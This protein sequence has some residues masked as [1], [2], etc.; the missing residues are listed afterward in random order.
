MTSFA[1]ILIAN[2][3]EIAARIARTCRQ[4]GIATVAVYS[5]ADAHAPFVADCDEAVRLPGA[6]AA[7]TYL[8]VDLVV[9]AALATGADA[10]HPG[11]GFLSESPHLAA[12][13]DEAGVTFI[14]PP[15]AAIA[16]MSSKIEAKATMRDAGVPVLEGLDASG[17]DGAAL[18]AAAGTLGYPLLAKGS[19]SGGGKGI[20][21]V[22]APDGLADAVAVA[23]REALA[24][25]GDGTVL[26]ERYLEGAR[27]VE[28]Q[29]IADDHGN[30]AHLFERE[31]SIQRRHQKIIEEC[32]SPVVDAALRERMGQAA[33]AATNAVG[34][35]GAGTVEFLLAG[36]GFYFME[37]NTRL[38]VEHP[39]TEMVTGLDLVRLQIRV[40]EGEPLPPE[41]TAATITGH[42]IEAR[43]YAEDPAAGFLPAVGR[44]HRFRIPVGVR[45][46]AGVADGS[47]VTV[48]YDPLLAKVIAHAPTRHE[49][50]AA[51]AR[52][53]AGAELYGVTTNR[54]LLVGILRS[55]E[56]LTGAT[57][58]GFIDRID[59]SA[60]A[61]SPIADVAGHA[62]AATLGH[63][64]RRRATAAVQASIPSGWRN[65]PSQ[66]QVQEWDTESGTTVVGYR[67]DREGL[68]AEIDGSPLAATLHRADA[69]DV[70]L[71]IGGVRRRYRMLSV[72]DTTWVSSPL[73]QATLTRLRRFPDPVVHEAPG[74]LHSPMP[75]KVVAVAVEIG[76]EVAAGDTIVVIEAM[77]MEHSVRS[78]ATGVVA[79][80]TVTVGQQV[81]AH[82]V[83][84]V[85]EA[86]A[87][88]G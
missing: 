19:A 46:D 37:M 50:A 33:V 16:A 17:L 59:V 52:A 28:I 2:R 81:D 35:V 14:G 68:V 32:P 25:F 54:D 36:D 58:T 76:A 65:A 77:K 42:A 39:V 48:H 49:A 82:Q 66:L 51:L 7:D 47:E 85:V 67:F 38:Q 27:H 88:A 60:M 55:H 15:A 63:Q 71:T 75:G 64:A 53:L 79:A 41:V 29:V 30:V 69:E 22:T 1:K 18:T 44:L 73:G 57:D 84:A 62:L 13:C 23:G 78:P 11:Y 80:V 87:P 26:L 8:R 83:V 9:E 70:D 3:G 86:P 72:D 40:A 74:S 61:A 20:R 56:F 12:A 4:M 21:V 43:L 45:V 10:V 5:D 34:Y 31:C 6:A 24:A